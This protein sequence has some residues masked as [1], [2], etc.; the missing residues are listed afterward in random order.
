VRVRV[1]VKVRIRVSV[2]VRV[3]VRV[4]VRVR[5]G[6][7]VARRDRASRGEA[8]SSIEGQRATAAPRLGRARRWRPGGGAEGGGEDTGMDDKRG[9]RTTPAGLD[10]ATGGTYSLSG[11]LVG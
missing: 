7:R 1:K 6:D 4:S 11:Q 5:V 10:P 9:G 8:G 3:R 2:G